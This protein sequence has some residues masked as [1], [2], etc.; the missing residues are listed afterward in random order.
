VA[1]YTNLRPGN[2]QFQVNACN[3]HGVWN[4][5]PKEFPFFLAPYIWQTWPFYVAGG[6]LALSSALAL[7]Y[8]RVRGLRRLQRLEQQ[9]TLQEERARIARDLHDD[10][11]ASLTGVALQLEAAQSRGHAEGAQLAVLAGETR[12]LAHELRELAWATNPRCDNTVSLAAFIGELAE[13]FCDAAGLEC[14]L[15]LPS[16]EGSRAVPARVRH[17]LL[18]VVKESLANVASHAAA[19]HVTVALATSGAEVRV[20][21]QDD[22][23][24]FDPGRAA[25]GT[26]LRNLQ[27][28]LQQLG[29]SFDIQ[30]RPGTGTIVTAGLP[31]QAPGG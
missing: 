29:G 3:N 26:G 24:G 31:L 21:I 11:G 14:K 2:Y 18:I 17:A 4:E 30:S 28:R 20:V 23:C 6:L 12:S 25:G 8:G 27:E 13:R 16:A 10:L 9:R 15:V 1:F 19:R 7:H 5:T 22:G